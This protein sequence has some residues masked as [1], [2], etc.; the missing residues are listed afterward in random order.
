MMLSI[1][2]EDHG[3]SLAIVNLEFLKHKIM[4]YNYVM[5]AL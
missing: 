1:L 4:N 5:S 2:E 3:R